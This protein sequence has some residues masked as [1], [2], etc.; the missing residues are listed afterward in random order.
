MS[1]MPYYIVYIVHRKNLLKGSF[2][3]PP[4]GGGLEN[5]TVFHAHSCDRHSLLQ[6]ILYSFYIQCINNI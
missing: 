5:I 1:Y 2:L 4:P 6:R 3:S